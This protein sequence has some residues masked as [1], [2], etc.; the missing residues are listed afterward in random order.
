MSDPRLLRLR[1]ELYAAAQT[2]RGEDAN[3]FWDLIT[4]INRMQPMFD[5]RRRGA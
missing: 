4:E 3:D 5:E 1:M 2:L